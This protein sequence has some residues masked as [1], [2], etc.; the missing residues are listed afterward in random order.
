[1]NARENAAS[2]KHYH[3]DNEGNLHTNET[4]RWILRVKNVLV[5]WVDKRLRDGD[6]F[7]VL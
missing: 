1:M 3:R 5:N 4:K 6:Q 2:P 7:A